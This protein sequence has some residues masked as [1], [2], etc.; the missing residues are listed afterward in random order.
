MVEGVD[1]LLEEKGLP[2]VL[3][4]MGDDRLVLDFGH[5]REKGGNSSHGWNVCPVVCND[6]EMARKYDIFMKVC[7]R[8]Y[9]DCYA[10]HLENEEKLK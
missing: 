1:F 2:K 3:G 10:G 8:D 5:G 9:N 6:C 7:S 4:K